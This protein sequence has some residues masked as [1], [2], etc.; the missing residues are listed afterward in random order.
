[1]HKILWDFEMQMDPPI[2]DKRSDL[3]LILKEENNLWS[4]SE[5]KKKKRK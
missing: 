5:K 1:M 2:S 3:A 4:Q